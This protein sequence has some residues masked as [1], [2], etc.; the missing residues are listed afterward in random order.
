MRRL[1][2]NGAPHGQGTL[3]YPHGDVFEGN[4]VNDKAHG[5]GKMTLSNG[6]V[7]DGEWVADTIQGSGKFVINGITYEGVFSQSNIIYDDYV[8]TCTHPDGSASHWNKTLAVPGY[9]PDIFHVL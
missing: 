6:D 9:T 7:Y 3:T 8:L 5:R 4:H 2:E 1:F